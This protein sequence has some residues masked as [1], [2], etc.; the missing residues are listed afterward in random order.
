MFARFL[1]AVTVWALVAGLGATAV[2]QMDEESP[3]TGIVVSVD[4][5]AVVDRAGV[6]EPVVEGC[7]LEHGDV[8]IV[9]AGAR[10]TGFTP[11]GESFQLEGPVELRLPDA[12]EHGLL[13][14]VSRWIREQLTQWIGQTRR[15]P[16]VTRTLLRDWDVT[17]D[18]PTQLIPAPNGRVRAS[19]AEFYW[20]TVP[21]IDSYL[22]TV[23]TAD[24]DETSRLV[25]DHGVI[26]GDLDPGG[27]Y[28]WKVQPAVDGWHG[29][30]RWR[31]FTV[32]TPGDEAEL[33]AAVAGL[34]G[35]EAGVLLLTA[36][37]H[38]EAIYRFDA[39]IS[40]NGDQARSAR[41]WRARALADIGLYR[42]AY[43]DV[44]QNQGMD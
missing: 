20:A 40:G 31:T 36:G 17:I 44:I 33:D 6:L 42:E 12:S 15:R 28:V 25:R 37:L 14:E 29:E 24:G 16:L 13:D 21:G 23:V 1:V 34:G 10:C 19:E 9:R 32:M 2:A 3:A 27:E 26:M 41:L 22:V 5:E 11:V 18:T 35:L 39:T 7:V 38:D 4:G 30:T 8:I 43:K